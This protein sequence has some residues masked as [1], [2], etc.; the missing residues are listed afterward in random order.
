MHTI[1]FY[2]SAEAATALRDGSP[3]PIRDMLDNLEAVTLDDDTSVFSTIIDDVVEAEHII[4][5]LQSNE[6]VESA[7]LKPEDATP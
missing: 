4:R 7:Y 6:Y 5:Q 2:V 1:V 3:H